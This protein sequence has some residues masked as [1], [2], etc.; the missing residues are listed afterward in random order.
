MSYVSASNI[1]CTTVYRI[2]E[3]PDAAGGYDRN[4]AVVTS[5]ASVEHNAVIDQEDRGRAAPLLQQVG[6]QLT[7]AISIQPVIGNGYIGYQKRVGITVSLKRRIQTA[8]NRI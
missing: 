2:E 5:A 6:S 8:V 4:I 1:S 3:W 7:I